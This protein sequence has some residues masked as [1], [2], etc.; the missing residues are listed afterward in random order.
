MRIKRN[1][2]MA[3]NTSLPQVIKLSPYQWLPVLLLFCLVISAGY[4]LPVVIRI[5][6]LLTGP[7]TYVVGAFFLVA[8]IYAA[9]KA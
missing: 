8:A 7:A 4:W 6:I 2:G 3:R 9:Q 1:A 5:A